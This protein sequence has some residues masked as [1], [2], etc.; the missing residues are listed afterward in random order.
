MTATISST[1]IQSFFSFQDEVKKEV[2]GPQTKKNLRFFQQKTVSKNSQCPL[3]QLLEQWHQLHCQILERTPH[4]NS[5]LGIGAV[6][7]TPIR[8]NFGMPTALFEIA[9]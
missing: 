1:T 9:H 6:T 3:G 7:P 8:R 5:N 2:L 4:S